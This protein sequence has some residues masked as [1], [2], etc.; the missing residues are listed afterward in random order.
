MVAISKRAAFIIGIFLLCVGRIS[1][2]NAASTL[3]MTCSGNLTNTR[4]DGVTLGQCDLNFISVKEMDEV[5][6]TC[7]IPG[8][9]DTPAE[10]KCRI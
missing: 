7:G 10:N 3:K 6:K 2:G 1:D 9:I 8:T 5:E 4:E